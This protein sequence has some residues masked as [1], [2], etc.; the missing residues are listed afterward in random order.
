MFMKKNH[1]TTIKGKIKNNPETGQ[2]ALRS[3]L[4]S[5]IKCGQI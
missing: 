5:E 3:V 4:I 1:G 2:R